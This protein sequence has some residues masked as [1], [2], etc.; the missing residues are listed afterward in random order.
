MLDLK[1]TLDITNSVSGAREALAFEF[2]APGDGDYEIFAFYI[3]G[4]GQTADPSSSV[5]YT[6]NYFDPYGVEALTDYWSRNVLTDQVKADLQRSGRGE[7]YMDSLELSTYGQGSLFWGFTLRDEFK[8]RRGYDVFTYLP[9]LVKHAEPDGADASAE[10]DLLVAAGAVRYG[11]NG[12]VMTNYLAERGES[13][14]AICKVTNDLY[15]TMTELY[16]ENT[17]GPLRAWLHSRHMKLRAEPSYG[18]TL[19]ISTPAKYLD[20][21]EIESYAQCAEID[22]YRNMLGSANMYARPFSSETGA[23]RRRNYYY[24]MDDWTQLAYLQFAVG[25]VRTVLARLGR[26]RRAGAKHLLAGT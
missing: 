19:E 1:T 18:Y 7:L 25:V 5:N 22:L 12:R 23:V 4:T 3:H 6:I 21:V 14:E 13:R 16:C 2:T 11:G 9:F 26:H 20:G 10:L 24:N 15:R 17:L 8:K